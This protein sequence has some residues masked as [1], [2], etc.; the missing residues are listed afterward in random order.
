VEFFKYNVQQALLNV[1]KKCAEI[2][3]SLQCTTIG[4]ADNTGLMVEDSLLNNVV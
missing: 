1:I 4:D 2:F 3:C